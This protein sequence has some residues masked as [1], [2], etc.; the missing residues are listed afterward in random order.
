MRAAA[1]ASTSGDAS[2]S[3]VKHASLSFRV[4]RFGLSGFSTHAIPSGSALLALPHAAM[5][6]ESVATASAVGRAAVAA[7]GSAPPPELTGRALL[8]VYMIAA[9]ARGDDARFS[10]YLRALPTD[11][12]DPLWW[13]ADAVA[14][15]LAGT[16][17]AAA[18]AHRAR[19]LRRIFDAVVAPLTAARPADFPAATFSFR[20]WMWAHSCFSSRGFP[21][22]LAE[23][24]IGGGVDEGAAGGA[25]GGVAGGAARV[26]HVDG[27]GGA[28]AGDDANP[29]ASPDGS[30][31][32]CML[33]VLDILNHSPTARVEWQRGADAVTF[34]S[35]DAIGAGAEVYNNYG[36][37]G[38]EE[39]LL[40]F[41]FVVRENV[42][43][44]V[45]LALAVDW[46][47][48]LEVSADCSRALA[49]ATGLGAAGAPT[50]FVVTRDGVA[51]PA[52]VAALRLLLAGDRERTAL[53]VSA[54]DDPGAV[55]AALFSPRRAKDEVRVYSALRDMLDAKL[56]ALESV[57]ARLAAV[58]GAGAGGGE[59]A[60]GGA[61]NG[62][63]TEGLAAVPPGSASSI[64]LLSV[65][66]GR[67]G[68]DALTLAYD[69]CTWPC[70][71]TAAQAAYRDACAREY[72]EG[73]LGVLRAA[74][75][76]ARREVETASAR[77]RE[78]KR[79]RL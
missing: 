41:G 72:V 59:E 11:F 58:H 17:L 18:V 13:S 15:R 64:R 65:G 76:H 14:A 55:K 43:D 74:T 44:S 57:L 27:G 60:G 67:S 45:A 40:A 29:L 39:L 56:A 26:V 46:T 75:E 42:A 1:D 7:L 78:A 16:N 25:V 38:N 8:Y 36:P 31:V 2:L 50:R 53:A 68:A 71:E 54:A 5:L 61:A 20:A 9:R 66:D 6:T 51:P 77:A 22:R 35:C 21:A 73:Q 3:V 47:R 23:P 70:P 63:A 79:R 33:P 48:E 24:P 49:A 32:G 28:A 12:D 30:P 19:W 69:D 52:L 37:K 4:S 10:E 34:I 62:A